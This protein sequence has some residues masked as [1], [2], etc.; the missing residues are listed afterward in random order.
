M[1]RRKK[2]ERK[3]EEG[4]RKEEGK[5]GRVISSDSPVDTQIYC[6]ALM[7]FVILQF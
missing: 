2:K 7:L 5:G 4:G 3:K 1:S 6:V